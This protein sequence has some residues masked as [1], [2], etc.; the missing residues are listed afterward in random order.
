M[1][2]AYNTCYMNLNL[3]PADADGWTDRFAIKSQHSGVQ[4]FEHRTI[5]HVFNLVGGT[6]YTAAMKIQINGGTWNY[7]SLWNFE[8]MT[9]KA[10]AK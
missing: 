5:R 6:T 7:N 4:Q 10:W 1:D 9:G 8:H 2:A 3:S